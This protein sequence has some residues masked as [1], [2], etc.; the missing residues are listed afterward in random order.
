MKLLFLGTWSDGGF[1]QVTKALGTRFLAA[2]VDIRILAVD[3]RGQPVPG[4]LQGRV[5]PAT[6][7]GGSHG[8]NTSAAISGAFWRTLDKSDDWKPDVVLAIEDMTG[9]LARMGGSV[10][11]EWL[12]LPVFHYVPIEGDNLPPAWRPVWDLFRPVAMSRYGARVIE[13][14]IG[15]GVPM[16]YHGV[17]TA[18][19]RP[20]AP[21]DPLVIDGKRLGTREACKAYF[22]RDPS[23]NL[24]LRSDAMVTRKFYDRFLA[25]MVPVL[26]AS[27][28]TD[29]LLHT[30]P[31]R[32]GI[33]MV[34]ELMRLPERL[35]GRILLTGMHDTWTG[36]P[37]EGLVAL[38]NAADVYVSTTGGEGFGLNLAESLACGVPVVVTD[39]AAEAEV[40]GPGGYLIPPL[41]DAYGEAVRFHST[42]GMD[43]A[44]PDPKG[45]AAP[46]LELLNRPSRRRAMGAEGR[47]HVIRSFSWDTATSE[48]LTLF[49]EA[50]APAAV[51]V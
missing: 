11:K 13:A 46:V 32:D 19:F 15:R 18:V 36:L 1:G 2:G 35:R 6:M 33:D 25:A 14:H 43:W 7:L 24:I 37:L 10:D 31:M 8:Q 12:S 17:D 30:T 27:P 28:D 16:V 39:W 3:H 50:H 29:V 34:Q 21:N 47:A 22:G 5:W 40:V 44:V 49:E 23:R 42:F 51:A 4:P 26:D 45:F 38:I 20:V 48:F 9:L 41:H